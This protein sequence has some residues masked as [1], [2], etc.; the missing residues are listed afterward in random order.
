M[1][2]LWACRMS[3]NMYTLRDRDLERLQAFKQLQSLDLSQC[4]ALTD[5]AGLQRLPKLQS[6]QLNF[7]SG[8][9]AGALGAL[10]QLPRLR[11]LDLSCCCG[12]TDEC[13]ASITGAQNMP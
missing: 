9:T 5:L 4:R 10:A 2:F 1:M 12:L 11:Q 6:L 3:G 8:L 13:M 7:C